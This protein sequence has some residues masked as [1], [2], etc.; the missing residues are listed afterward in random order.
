M[1]KNLN[2]PRLPRKAV[3]PTAKTSKYVHPPTNMHEVKLLE[4]GESPGTRN[5]VLGLSPI[6][7]SGEGYGTWHTSQFPGQNLRPED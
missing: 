3:A 2:H 7:Q 5:G 6:S 4:T 1:L